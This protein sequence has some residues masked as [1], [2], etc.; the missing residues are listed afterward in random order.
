MNL[1]Q[2]IEK[3]KIILASQSPRRIELLGGLNI[4]FEVMVLDVNEDFPAQMVGVDIPMY[5]AEKKANAYK[6]IMD[7]HTMIITADTIVWH[8]GKVLGKPVDETDAR[9]MLRALS[10]KTHQVITGVCIS[11]LQRRKVFHV[12]SDVRFARLAEVE[13]EYYLQNFKPYDKA[14]SYG[15]QEWIGFVGVEHINGSYF[16]V[17]GL[18]VQRLYNELKRWKE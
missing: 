14:G 10:G 17:M 4:K 5:L 13:I 11:T 12:I 16:N 6:H 9:R 1:L 18:P 7:E 8:E 2:N 3:Y 15:V